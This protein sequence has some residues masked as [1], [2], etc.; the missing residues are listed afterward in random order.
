MARTIH[1]EPRRITRRE[2]CGFTCRYV[3]APARQCVECL[4]VWLDGERPQHADD[5]LVVEMT[6]TT[7]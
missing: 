2:W 7:R 6:R 4:C 1:P 5:C 3:D